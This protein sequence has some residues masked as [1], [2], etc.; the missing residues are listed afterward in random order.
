MTSELDPPIKKFDQDLADA[1]D[2]FTKEEIHNYTGNRPPWACSS[3]RLEM[4][5]VWNQ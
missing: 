4:V 3:Y 1:P 5:K 2:S